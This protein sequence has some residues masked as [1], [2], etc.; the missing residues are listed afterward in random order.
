MLL[1]TSVIVEIFRSP[2][3]SRRHRKI[4]KE[5]GEEEVFVSVIQLAE[6]AD[7]AV[8]NRIPPKD[9][10]ASIKEFARIVPL[11]EQICLDASVIKYRRRELGYSDFGL[12]DSIVLAT[13]RSIG[14]RVLT[15][16]KDF[17]GESDCLVIS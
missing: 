17:T 5:I 4:V 12:L 2:S 11:D 16:D 6:V 10:V 3:A 15:F 8:R 9:R 13:A 1:D 7:W 14:Q